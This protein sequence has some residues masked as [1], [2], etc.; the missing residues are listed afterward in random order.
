MTW[1][2]FKEFFQEN[3]G[4]SKAFVDSVWKKVKRNSQYQNKL[5]QDWAAHLKYF[6]S[7]LIEF[8][9]EWA[10][11]KG[12]MIWYFREGLRSLVRV[13]I[14]QCSQELNSF[15]ELVEKTVD[16]KAKAA[17]CPRSYT[18]KTDQ[19][20]LRGSRPSAAKASTQGQPIKDPRVKGLK[21]S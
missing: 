9:S 19:H 18:C 7:I 4:N 21:K 6:Q 8:D 2:E 1:P 20:C 17:L 16:A 14:E 11:E 5:V 3:L 13:E 10:P 12:I 15:K